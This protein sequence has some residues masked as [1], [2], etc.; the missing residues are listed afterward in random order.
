MLHVRPLLSGRD[1]HALHH[2]NP[3]FRFDPLGRRRRC[4][5]LAA[6]SRPAADRR[7]WRRLS[8]TRRSG[9]GSSSMPRKPRAASTASRI[10]LRRACCPGT[11]RRAQA[12]LAWR[13]DRGA[14][15]GRRPRWPRPS[16]R[17]GPRSR[18]CIAPRSRISRP[19]AHR[20]TLIAGYPWFTDWG[21]DTFIALR[22]L[23][24]ATG[25]HD[26]ALRGAAG[27]GRAGRSRACCPTA[28]P[29]AAP[30]P[31]TTAVDA[32]LWFIVAVHDLLAPHA[33]AACRRPRAL[34]AACLRSWA[35]PPARATASRGRGWAVACRRAGRAAYLDGRQGR[36]LGGDA[37]HRQAG[38]GA[39]AVD[40]CAGHRRR[41]ASGGRGARCAATAARREPSWRGSPDA[42]TG[43]LA[44]RDR[45]R[46]A[47]RTDAHPRRTRFSPPA[48]CRISASARRSRARVLV[49]GRGAS[50]DAA[51]ACA[52]STRPMPAYR[53]RYQGGVRERDG[54]YHQ[55]TVWPWLLGPFVA[56]WLR[57]R[58]V[59]RGGARRGRGRF[60]RAAACASSTEAGLG[61]FGDRRWRP[62]A[63]AARLSV[64]GLVH[65]RAAA[66]RERC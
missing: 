42:A 1:Y 32:S 25:R 16:G 62:A 56:A 45:R 21:R 48:A 20:Q 18:R 34:R 29:M 27:L 52:R 63:H 23:L 3:A 64:P 59:T 60:L 47:R 22:G 26:A 17:A 57:L 38:G 37:A 43:G 49:A 11:C 41:L 9:T 50:A 44:R 14:G 36:R 54:A 28:F 4:R 39:G 66:H 51:R 61:T 40:Q 46:T 30:R 58:G 10:W 33:R 35:T 12:T 31:S 53:G 65:R 2:E 24:L 7:A 8:L 55:G 6:L 5:D 15:A 19:R 13:A